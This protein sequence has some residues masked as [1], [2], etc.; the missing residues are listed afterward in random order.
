MN[1]KSLEYFSHRLLEPMY[2]LDN[3]LQDRNHPEYVNVMYDINHIDNKEL[4]EFVEKTGIDFYIRDRLNI[5]IERRKKFLQMNLLY[6]AIAK[7]RIELLSSSVTFKGLTS[8]KLTDDDLMDLSLFSYERKGLTYGSWGYRLCPTIKQDNSSYW[9]FQTLM[10]LSHQ[11]KKV[12]IRLDPLIEIPLNEYN[13]IEYK[14]EVYCSPLKWN[15]IKQLKNENHGQFMD[16]CTNAM[17]DYIW[18]PSDNEIHFTCEELPPINDCEYR[19]S[20]YFHAIINKSTGQIM[21]CDGAV[22][23]YNLEELETRNKL[24]LKDSGARKMGKRIK[25]FRIDDILE[26]SL[27]TQLVSSFYVWNDDVNNYMRSICC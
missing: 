19:G 23:F 27:F 8:M 25:I 5:D 21:H 1:L 17:T 15:Q 16:N 11:G 12:F 3:V 6:N 2:E 24:H 10:N 20:R 22:R 18:K 7:K 26:Q 9:L 14:M 4:Q 13:Q